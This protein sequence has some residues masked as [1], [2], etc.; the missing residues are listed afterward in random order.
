MRNKICS[1]LCKVLGLYLLS[2]CLAESARWEEPE[3]TSL[4]SHILRAFASRPP[5]GI[6]KRV[7]AGSVSDKAYLISY[8]MCY[9]WDVAQDTSLAQPLIAMLL[10][11]GSCPTET[12]TVDDKL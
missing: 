5:K 7:S 11:D 12:P 1:V 10:V 2:L 6:D 3:I 4:R 8:L 9:Q